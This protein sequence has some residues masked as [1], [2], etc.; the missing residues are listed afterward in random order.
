[1]KRGTGKL[2]GALLLLFAACGVHAVEGNLVAT[3]SQNLQ[4]QW[5]H[6]LPGRPPQIPVVSRVVPGQPFS[7]RLVLGRFALKDGAADVTADLEQVNPDG[8]KKTIGRDLVALRG[9]SDGKGVFLSNFYLEAVMEEKDAPGKYRIVGKLRDRNDGSE[10]ALECSWELTAPPD[11]FPALELKQSGEVLSNYYRSPKP[12][13]LPGL[14]ESCLRERPGLNDKTLSLYYGLGRLF[15]LNPQ[16]HGELL[17]IAAAQQTAESRRAVAA[18]IHFLGG[19]A[20]AELRP[21]LDEGTRRELDELALLPDEVPGTIRTAGELDQLWFEFFATGKVEPIRRLVDQLARPGEMLT[22]KEFKAKKEKGETTPED[23]EKLKNFLIT[24]AA[25]WSLNS[26]AKQH[27][28]VRFYLEAMLTRG[29]IKHPRS[30]ALVK[31]ILRKASAPAE[32][33]GK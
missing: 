27:P 12:E 15:R 14:L 20:E 7:I 16:L 25:N 32:K 23:L 19:K 18:V 26:N 8:T 17:R 2:A 21:K 1:M 6:I 9:K 33:A 29:E 3:L 10:K 13:L 5:E 31:E 30:A 24:L 22:P 11:S 4:D 28:L